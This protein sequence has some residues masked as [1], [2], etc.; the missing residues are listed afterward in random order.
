MRVV[1]ASQSPRRKMLLEQLGLH[2][3][4]KPAVVDETINIEADP[5]RTCIKLAAMKAREVAE[6][7]PEALIIAADTIVVL[8]NR[9]LGKPRHQEEAFQM[10]SLLSGREHQVITGLCVLNTGNGSIDS[11]A[12]ITRVRFR[13]ILEKEIRAY[14]DSGEPLDKAGSYG[15][16]G[17]GAVFV[18]HMEGCFYNVVGLPIYTLYL[19]LQK[20]GV[21]LLGG[22]G[23]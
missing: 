7:E 18:E 20:Q 6:Q 2:F 9:I 15:V 8:D 14:I 1:L 3:V 17:L 21:H 22:V 23:D 11:A 4:C 16:Q 5:A 19:M 13:T 10:L 12:V